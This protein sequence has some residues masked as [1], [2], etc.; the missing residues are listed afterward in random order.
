MRQR[1]TWVCFIRAG[2]SGPIKIGF[3]NDVKD[4]LSS[5]QTSHYESLTLLGVVNA[6]ICSEAAMHFL[7]KKDHIRGEW[8]HS[9]EELLDFIKINSHP[10]PIFPITFQVPVPRTNKNR[11]RK[12][13]LKSIQ[14]SDRNFSDRLDSFHDELRRLYRSLFG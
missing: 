5:L 2:K 6:A 14:K 12:Q 1:A 10:I 8:F 13:L 9:S 11:E 3:S 7:H 4:R